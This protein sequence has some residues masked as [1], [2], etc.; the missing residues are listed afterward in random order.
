MKRI[1][2][3]A[4]LLPAASMAQEDNVSYNYF[5][6]DYFRTDWD[7]GDTETAGEG[8]MGRFSVGIRNHVYI[9]GE[10]RAW[11]FDETEPGWRAPVTREQEVDDPPLDDCDQ[12]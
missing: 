6:I 10:Y 3:L 9:A 5:D 4:L 12:G 11:E 2:A 1:F 7:F 8:W